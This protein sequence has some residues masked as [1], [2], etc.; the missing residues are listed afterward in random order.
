MKLKLIKGWNGQE[1]LISKE[2]NEYLIKKLMTSL[3]WEDFNAVSLEKNE[4]NWIGV[5]GNTTSEGLALVYQEKGDI[6]VSK[7]APKSIDKLTEALVS[8]LMGDQ[9][10]K[11]NEFISTK[12]KLT[13]QKSAQEYQSWKKRY[14]IQ[15]A[16]ENKKTVKAYIASLLI[17]IIITSFIYLLATDELRF[18]GHNTEITEA[19]V[20]EIQWVTFGEGLIQNVIYEF[21]HEGN[22]YSGS[23]KGTRLTG[24][25][26]VDEVVFIKFKTEKPSV[27]K[28][29]DFRE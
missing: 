7:Y 12:P 16:K 8:Y 3:N 25:F 20:T 2:P 10:F 14:E 17:I 27:S 13:I 23:F 9:T 26:L 21:E 4:N 29:V 22:L 1:E 28:R 15:K 24:K 19:T 11:K 6:Y 18:L 5:S